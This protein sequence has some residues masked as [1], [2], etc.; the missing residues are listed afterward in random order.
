MRFVMLLAFV[1]LIGF[2]AAELVPLPENWWPK[3]K[4][5]PVQVEPVEPEVKPRPR[6]YV[7]TGKRWLGNP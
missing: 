2:A 4:T 7:P 5:V 1:A 6:P 3:P